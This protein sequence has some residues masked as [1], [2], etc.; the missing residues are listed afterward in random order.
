[1]PNKI[2]PSL[3]EFRKA[4]Q[5]LDGHDGQRQLAALEKVIHYAAFAAGHSLAEI[6]QP[7]PPRPRPTVRPENL[8]EAAR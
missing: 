5:A 4:V 6:Y 8:A 7:I 1:M 3:S 2:E